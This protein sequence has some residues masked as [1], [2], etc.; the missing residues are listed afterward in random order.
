MEPLSARYADVRGQSERIC[1]PLEIEDYVIQS[2][3]DAS[4]ARWHLAHTTWFFET[5][6][7]APYQSHWSPVDARYAVLFNS[8]YHTVGPQ[9]PR[10]RRGALSRPTV[11]EIYR[12]RTGVDDAVAG[13]LDHPPVEHAGEIARRIE[14][15]LH[16]EQQHQ[17]LLVTDLKHGLCTNPLVPAYAPAPPPLAR[18][19]ADPGFVTLPGGV[20]RVGH[21]GPGFAFDNETPAHEVLLRDV[22]LGRD[23]VTAGQYL[24]FI[25]DGGYRR[26]DLWLDDGWRWV[27]EQHIE[28]PLYWTL[29]DGTWTEATLYG[30]RPVDL[31]APVTHVSHY[32]AD[33]YARWAGARLPTE[34]EWERAALRFGQAPAPGVEDG[35]LHPLGRRVPS[36]GPRDLLGEVWEWTGSAYLPY[37]GFRPLP[38]AIG[39]YNGKFMSGQMVLRGG[40]VASPRG[41]V[42]TSYRNFFQ[43]DKRWQFTGF[44]LARD[45]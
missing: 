19:A 3:P 25:E 2:M 9:F 33:A 1:A 27:Q 26:P 38:G 41:H 5:F 29:D 24:G 6:V 7:L 10:P 44:R 34:H 20:Y 23:L 28:A 16:H 8:Y 12:Y 4:P 45:A 30:P 31:E 14:L 15:G 42:R 39:E 17:E 36:D 22:Q 43:P 18:P 11:A 13:L 40:S 32:E 37:P 21:D 35:V